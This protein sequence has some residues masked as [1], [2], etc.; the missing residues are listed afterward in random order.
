MKRIEAGRFAPLRSLAPATPRAFAALVEKC[1]RGKPKKRFA[2][3]TA[4]RRA[5]ERQLGSPSASDCR[6]EI[7]AWLWERKVFKAKRGQTARTPRVRPASRAWLRRVVAAAAAGL[8][9]AALGFAAEQGA[10][11]S[12]PGLPA[13]AASLRPP[14]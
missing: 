1:L 8:V 11:R 13:F 6:E 2:T 3:T 14:P 5:L 9:L 10:L 7:A 12:L 4:L